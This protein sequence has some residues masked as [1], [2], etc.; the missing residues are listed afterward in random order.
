MECGVH[1]ETTISDYAV[2]RFLTL[3]QVWSVFE[4]ESLFTGHDPEL[5][6]YR[7]RVHVAEMIS[8]LGPPPRDLL[9]QGK[10][11]DKFFTNEGEQ[12]SLTLL[13]Q[14][15][16]LHHLIVEAT[17]VLKCQYQITFHSRTGRHLSREK[18]KRG[19]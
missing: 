13:K 12:R 5:Q 7:S 6:T 18:T 14:L 2:P 8:L 9:V 11:S 1:G 4:N 17:S 15:F 10:L 3:S 16:H 19:F